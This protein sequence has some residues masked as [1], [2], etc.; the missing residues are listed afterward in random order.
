MYSITQPQNG[1]D[2]DPRAIETSAGPP[3]VIYSDPD[4]L[5]LSMQDEDDRT[6]SPSTPRK[7]LQN[8]IRTEH[9]VRNAEVTNLKI[10]KL[11][12]YEP[13]SAR[14]VLRDTLITSTPLSI[15]QIVNSRIPNG[16]LAH[17]LTALVATAF[18]PLKSTIYGLSKTRSTSWLYL[19]IK[20]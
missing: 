20:H 4:G 6:L 3:F 10:E 1:Q 12:S 18:H 11:A 2:E 7:L 16:V 15:T 13:R 14:N 5:S 9:I 8:V 17:I 19:L